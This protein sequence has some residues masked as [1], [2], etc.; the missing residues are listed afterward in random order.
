MRK[1]RVVILYLYMLLII[2]S[3]LYADE[4]KFVFE[5]FDTIS[6]Y[7]TPGHIDNVALFISGDGGWNSGVINM[8]RE[9]SSMNTLV[10]GVNVIKYL[11]HLNNE[12]VKCTYPAGDFEILSKFTQKK[13]NLPLY[14]LPVVVGYSSGA[15]L[16]YSLLAQAP[17]GTFKGAISIGFCPGLVVNKPLCEGIGLLSEPMPDNKGYNM[18]PVKMLPEPWIVFQG[19]NDKVCL[20]SIAEDY[21]KK[22]GNSSLIVLPNAGHGLPV[23]KNWIPQFR[24]AF[25]KIIV[26]SNQSIVPK[27]TAVS[28]L[29]LVEVQSATND[30]DCFV[31]LLTGDGGWAG[32]DKALA[33]SISDKGIPVVGF[34]TLEYFWN[35]RT[36][37][38][39]SKDLNRVINHY[40]K[41]WKKNRFILIGYSFGADILPFL[42]NRI[43]PQVL[44]NARLLTFLGLSKYAEFQFHISDWLGTGPGKDARPVVPEMEK[45]KGK[46]MLVFYGE[47][48]KDTPIEQMPGGLCRVV[49]LPGGHHFKGNYDQIAEEIVKD[50]FE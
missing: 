12:S 15:T 39:S 13:M 3:S 1:N 23:D 4:E 25:Q 44:N 9:L 43:N 14:K 36:P 20:P 34:N 47:E 40:T 28:G 29:P 41:I 42:A 21:T 22:V 45:L 19:A 8:A 6:L 33:K 48:E 49:K 35:L 10:A 11:S 2:S 38:E 50:A 31:I 24:E 32:I 16:A 27:D 37:E 5:K 7:Y 30:R 18:L 46:K 26:T 17:S